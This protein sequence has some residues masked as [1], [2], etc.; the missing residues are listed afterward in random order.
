MSVGVDRL[1]DGRK[2]DFSCLDQLALYE[3]LM[4]DDW[5]S[6]FDTS[7]YYTAGIDGR[8]VPTNFTLIQN[9]LYVSPLIA[10][11]RRRLSKMGVYKNNGNGS[12]TMR[13][14]VWQSIAKHNLFPGKLLFEDTVVCGVAG[15]Y[16]VNTPLVLEPGIL[17]WVG[18]VMQTANSGSWIGSQ[19]N[20]VTPFGVYGEDTGLVGAIYGF[21]HDNVTGKLPDPFPP[22]PTTSLAV[23]A[24]L[25]LTIKVQWGVF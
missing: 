18:G 17:Y 2:K 9:R 15:L 11:T 14:G 13:L 21:R 4:R 7:R 1:F 24:T 23:G 22:A 10:P 19:G 8:T 5:N 12:I 6:F 16:T 3:E 20:I 25:E